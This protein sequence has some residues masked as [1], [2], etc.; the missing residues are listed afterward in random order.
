[1]T[2]LLTGISGISSN[3]SMITT[4]SKKDRIL[5]THYF[6]NQYSIYEVTSDQLLQKEVPDVKS[7]DMKNG[8]LPITGLNKPDYVGANFRNADIDLKA[9]NPNV[10]KAKYKPNFKLDYIG[11]GA[12]VGVAVNNNSFRNASGLQGGIDMLFGDLLGN[13][14][15]YSQ[16]ALNG[17][18][19]DIGGMV[20]YIN[21]KNR[22]A[23]GV[24]LSHVPLRTGYQNLENTSIRFSDGV[25][26]QV[27]KESTNLIRVFDQNLSLFGL[28]P[29]STTLR[30]EGGIA[31]NARSFR[32]DEYNNYYLPIRQGNTL[33]GYQLVGSDKKRIPTEDELQLDQYYTVI[34][35]LG[36]S[37]NIGL[38]GDNSYFGLT[39]PLAGHR[40]R[41]NLEKF[42]GNDDY[43]GVLVDGRK[44]LWMKPVSLAFRATSYSRFVNKT[45]SVYPNYIGT[46]GFVR[47]LGSI[48]SSNVE[49]LGISFSQLLGSKM[50]LGS[51]ETRL[52]LSGPKSLSLIP[53]R[54]FLTDLNL[55][56]DIGTAFDEF[57]E[58]SDGKELILVVRDA[59]NN[60]VLDSNGDPTYSV[61]NVKPTIISSVGIS[62]RINLFG[63][64]IIEPYYARPLLKG[65]QFTFGLNL[66]PGW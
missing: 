50:L 40:F 52:P 15:L 63:S 25:D 21:R 10:K 54:Y 51:F 5:Y 12:G 56:F 65:G 38:V 42:I 66:I 27:I 41:V 23:W 55:F 39:A 4:S 6:K 18:F 35:G 19:L 7:I 57:K 3:S 22:L 32:W 9:S 64:L 24:G 49:N 2:D 33:T 31:G 47:G 58:F 46:M 17:D 11:G 59:N 60:I 36:A 30:L 13:N 29:F 14:Q 62:L 20:S 28:L 43:L 44:Y 8:T 48:L 53:S 1:M 37:A 16:L 26:R 45:N 34:K 61:R